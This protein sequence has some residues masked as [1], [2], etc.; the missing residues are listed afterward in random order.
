MLN[1]NS[2]NVVWD[3]TKLSKETVTEQGRAGQGTDTAEVSG[4]ILTG[5]LHTKKE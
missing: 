2:V 5:A 3:T 4:L 1:L